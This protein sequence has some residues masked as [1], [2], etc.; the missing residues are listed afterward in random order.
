MLAAGI[1]NTYDCNDLKTAQKIR[2]L[3]V[4]SP[5]LIALTAKR[6]YYHWDA[7]SVLKEA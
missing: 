4:R 6:G 1:E 3:P 7:V 2:S 5:S